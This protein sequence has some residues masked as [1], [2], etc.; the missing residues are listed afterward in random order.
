MMWWNTT[1]PVWHKIHSDIVRFLHW[2]LIK[3]SHADTFNFSNPTI[4]FDIKNLHRTLLLTVTSWP[5]LFP[6]ILPQE[7]H[8]EYICCLDC[9]D[10]C[11]ICSMII[12]NASFFA[13]TKRST[14]NLIYQSSKLYWF[15]L[16]GINTWS[17]VLSRQQIIYP[18]QNY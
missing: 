14:C 12:L 18:K 13:A 10:I 9:D 3:M 4:L 2:I 5:V 11:K 16:V 1:S 7:V 6:R 17:T 8:N 15:V